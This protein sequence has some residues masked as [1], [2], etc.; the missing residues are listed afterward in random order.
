MVFTIAP[1]LK[2]N[3]CRAWRQPSK[4]MLTGLEK[5]RSLPRQ[6]LFRFG[7]YSSILKYSNYTDVKP[8]SRH[9]PPLCQAEHW[10]HNHSLD[11][12]ECKIG[13]SHAYIQYAHG[14]TCL[15][16]DC[17]SHDFTHG[18]ILHTHPYSVYVVIISFYCIKEAS[19]SIK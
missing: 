6:R 5:F 19:A 15:T 18:F 10:C 3:V 12:G 8:N 14:P 7:V 17:Q 2:Q 11:G 9:H 4:H 16:E 13:L 1:V